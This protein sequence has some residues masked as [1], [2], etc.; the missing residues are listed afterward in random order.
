MEKQNYVKPV[1]EVIK[2]CPKKKKIYVKPMIEV[3]TADNGG[4]LD[5]LSSTVKTDPIPGGGDAKQHYPWEVRD[6]NDDR[7]MVKAAHESMWDI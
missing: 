1:I 3:I 6:W 5:S 7:A 4:I 2:A